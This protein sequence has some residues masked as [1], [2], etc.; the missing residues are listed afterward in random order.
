MLVATSLPKLQ[1]MLQQFSASAFKRD[2]ELHPDKTKVLANATRRTGR[3]KQKHVQVD[4]LSIEILPVTSA[5]KYLGRKICFIN[6]HETEL[7]NRM[8]AAWAKFSM[9]KQEL[10]SRNYSHWSCQAV[11]NPSFVNSLCEYAIKYF[12]PACT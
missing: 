1:K 10:T 5:T 6:N 9:L 11:H 4:D 2:L 7:D 12:A 3:G 8:R